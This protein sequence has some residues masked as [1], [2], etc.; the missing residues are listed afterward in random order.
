MK[1]LRTVSYPLASLL[2][3]AGSSAYA[4]EF[5]S[6]GSMPAILYDAPSFKGK[7]AFIA[8]RGMPVEVVLTYGEWTKVRDMAGDLSWVESGLLSNRRTVVVKVPNAKIRASAD[9]ASVPVFSCDKAVLLEL[10]E[11]SISGWLKVKHRDG[12][13]GFIKATD[14]WGV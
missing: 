13:S 12:Q 1:I 14:V 7:K 5:K 8:P 6:V 2:L 9:D 10:M 3:I 4:L 11:P